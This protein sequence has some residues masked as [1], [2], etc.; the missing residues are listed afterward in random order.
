MGIELPNGMLRPMPLRLLWTILAGG[1]ILVTNH[2]L[3]ANAAREG[4][5]THHAVKD[6]PVIVMLG[7]THYVLIQE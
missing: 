4:I 3:T 2:N 7:V 5:L 1:P 6:E